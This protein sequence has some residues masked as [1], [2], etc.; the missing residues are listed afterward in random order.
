MPAA[1][2]IPGRETRAGGGL[3]YLLFAVM[4]LIWASTWIAAGGSQR[5]AAALR[6]RRALRAGDACLLLFVR[7]L[8]GPCRRA[9]Q[10]GACLGRCCHGRPTASCSAP[11]QTVA[12]WRRRPRQPVADPGRPARPG[13]PD[14]TGEGRLAP[15]RG[16]AARHLRAGARVLAQCRL[17]RWPRGMAGRRRDRRRNLLL[18]LGAVLSRPLL[19]RSPP[20]QLTTAAGDCLACSALAVRAGAARS[21]RTSARTCDALLAPHWSPRCAPVSSARTIVAPIER[22]ALLRIWG[23]FR[24]AWLCLRFAGVALVAGALV[25]ARR[26]ASAAR[27]A[28]AA[29]MLAGAAVAIAAGGRRD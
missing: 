24:A 4:S 15:C 20:L 6:R 8:A 9:A 13:R 27:G 1:T 10:S 7:G 5:D 16:T 18:C 2:V 23:A 11:S 25:V 19:Q 26:E 17:R 22:T 3:N 14:G 28:G 12:T 21:R 29:T